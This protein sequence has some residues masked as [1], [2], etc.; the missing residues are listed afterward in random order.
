[1]EELL[2]KETSTF[3]VRKSECSRRILSR[4]FE[5]IETPYGNLTVKIGYEG[6]KIYK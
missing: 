4:R 5:K 1:M 3:G 2:L 6:D